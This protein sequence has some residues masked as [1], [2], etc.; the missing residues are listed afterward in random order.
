[1]S[2]SERPHVCGYAENGHVCVVT[3]DAEGRRTYPMHRC[4]CG[5]VW[6]ML[7]LAPCEKQL[8]ALEAVRD[9]GA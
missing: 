1:M 3:Y 4:A 9:V 2:E 5:Y 6:A 8:D 7:A